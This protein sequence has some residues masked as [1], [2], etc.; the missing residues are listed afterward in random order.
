MANNKEE[1]EMI[2][3]KRAAYN[4]FKEDLKWKT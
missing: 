4:G 3:V 1:M 2:M